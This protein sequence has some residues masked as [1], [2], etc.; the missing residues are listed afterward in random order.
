MSDPHHWRANLASEAT[1]SVPDALEILEASP[2]VAFL[3]RNDDGWPV[4]RVTTNV[5]RLLGYD[6]EDFVTGLIP[7]ADVVHP[8]DALRVI[9][10]VARYSSEPDRAEFAHEPYRLLHRDGSIRW[11]DD[12]TVIVRDAAGTITHFQGILLDITQRT[13]FELE[14]ARTRALDAAVGAMALVGGWEVELGTGHGYWSDQ[15]YSILGL[16]VGTALT[17]ETAFAGFHSEDRPLLQAAWDAMV[18]EGQ[19]FDLRLRVQG[20]GDGI[21]WTRAQGRPERECGKIIRVVGALQDITDQ[22]QVQEQLLQAQKSETL[23][24]L[25]AGIAHDFNNHLSYILSSC[26]LLLEDL[27]PEGSLA[28]S[29]RSIAQACEASTTLTQQILSYSRR[30]PARPRGVDLGEKLAGLSWSVQRMVG[31]GINVSAEFPETP[32]Y[33]RIDPHQLEQLV[34]NLVVNARDAMP[35]GGELSLDLQSHREIR[36]P[37]RESISSPGS[38]WCS[39]AVRD[40]GEGIPPE[41]LERVFEPFFTT[42][43]EGHGTGLGLASARSIVEANGGTISLTSSV[44]EGTEVRIFLPEVPAPEVAIES[45]PT[46]SPR[47]G[48]GTILLV[49]DEEMLR[50]IGVRLLERRGY[51]VLPFADAEKALAKLRASGSRIDLVLTDVTLPGMSGSQLVRELRPDFPEL[52]VILTSGYASDDDETLAPDVDWV[53][54]LPKPVRAE[55]LFGLIG[56]ILASDPPPHASPLRELG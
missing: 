20:V 42:K 46:R 37:E 23:G 30:N 48:V 39:L 10:E 35:M 31:A 22:V 47:D 43:A 50:D 55:E 2:A 51:S 32:V 26:S 1:N 4:E 56:E 24:R 12:R 5:H 25:A 49:E 9:D 33:V 19:P 8:D 21:R 3:W 41:V 11:V 7:Y 14:L 45:V 36:P 29:I 44:E 34:L 54:F 53:W 13:A 6:A 18:E 40:T 38:R 28:S 15:V 52:P 17:L 27:P 16:P